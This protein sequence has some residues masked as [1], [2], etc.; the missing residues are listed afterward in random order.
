MT[1]VETV[2]R[3]GLR[4]GRS[5]EWLLSSSPGRAHLVGI[6]GSGMQGLARLLAGWGWQITGS[7][8]SLLEQSLPAGLQD[9]PVRVVAGHSADH[10]PVDTDLLVYSAA[11]S[12]SNPERQQARLLAVPQFSY[13][14]VVGQCLRARQGVCISGTHGKSTTSAMVACLLEH[15]GWNPSALF[16]APLVSNGLS[17]WAGTGELF[18]VESCEF[19]RSF[20]QYAPHSAVILNIEPDHFDCFATEDELVTAFGDFAQSVSANGFLLVRSD[21]PNTM[22]AAQRGRA[23]LLTFGLSADADWWATDLKTTRQGTRFRVFRRGRFVT[24]VNLTIPGRHNV[25]NALAAGAMGCELGVPV[26]DVRLAL[27]Q[28]RG[29]RRRFEQLDAWR[30]ATRI[31]DY[32]HHPTAVEATLRAARDQFGSRRLFCLFEPHQISRTR[33]MIDRFAESLRLADRVAI[34]P[35]FTAR[36]SASAETALAVSTDLARRLSRLGTLA[37]AVPSLDHLIQLVDD[38]LLPGDVLLTLGAGDIHRVQHAI[39]RRVLRDPAA[40]R[41][42]GAVHLA[43][44]GRARAILAHTPE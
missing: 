43:E 39:T 11:I 41:V 24:E 19:Q 31:D 30:G 33:P 17:S 4:L 42:A 16:G 23:E 14:E 35:V 12:E 7:D 40:R 1:V 28:F 21:D 5:E 37:E 6:C 38:E 8:A 10:L 32:A 29:V 26:R 2:R 20:L 27:E 25:L 15:A 13:A 22:R 36:E 34:A 9:V 18:V 3:T 44:G